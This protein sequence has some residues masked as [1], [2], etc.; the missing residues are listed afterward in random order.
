MPFP[1]GIGGDLFPI[2]HGPFFNKGGLPREKLGRTG[3]LF[4]K[5]FFIILPPRGLGENLFPCC[6]PLNPFGAFL[7][8][9]A[10]L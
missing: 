9:R 8:R 5:P 3:F 10:P 7:G 1:L 4:K 2:I 6:V